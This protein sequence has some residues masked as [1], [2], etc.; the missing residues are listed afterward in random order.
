MQFNVTDGGFGIVILAFWALTL[1]I[2]VAFAVAIY[3]DMDELYNE[4]REIELVPELIWILATLLSGVLTVGV[5][6]IVHHMER[7][8][9]N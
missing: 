9:P 4:E 8:Q 1:I 7:R 5:Y 2:H 6:W 3:N